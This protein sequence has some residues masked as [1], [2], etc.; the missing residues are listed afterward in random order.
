MKIENK[1]KHIMNFIYKLKTYE[2]KKAFEKYLEK[3]EIKL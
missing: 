1:V 3:R 2:N